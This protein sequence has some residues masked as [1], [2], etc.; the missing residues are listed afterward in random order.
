MPHCRGT[1]Q[2]SITVLT[3]DHNKPTLR[4][5]KRAVFPYTSRPKTAHLILP[6][7]T[8]SLRTLRKKTRQD[9][10]HFAELVIFGQ[11]KLRPNIFK[12]CRQ[13]HSQ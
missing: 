2:P 4:K 11:M 12:T 8:H 13:S 5:I 3:S 7:H 9:K 1:V 10:I 6:N